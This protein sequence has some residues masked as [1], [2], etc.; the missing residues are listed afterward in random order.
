MLV[1]ILLTFVVGLGGCPQRHTGMSD[2][3]YIATT[4][5]ASWKDCIFGYVVPTLIGNVLGGVA[6]VAIVNPAQVV[7]RACL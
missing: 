1:I 7:K 2:R 5:A 4:G 3:F 6:L